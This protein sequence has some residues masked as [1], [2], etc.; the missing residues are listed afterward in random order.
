MLL[1]QASSRTATI[2]L[3][4]GFAVIGFFAGFA[5]L[6]SLADWVLTTKAL[7]FLSDVFAWVFVGL[8]SAS[9]AAIP[10]SAMLAQR[11]DDSSR[12]RITLSIVMMVGVWLATVLCVS[13]VVRF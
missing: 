4:V 3:A 12:Y 6:S 1:T 11:F 8:F 7:E 2:V 5:Y 13:L 9:V 10:V